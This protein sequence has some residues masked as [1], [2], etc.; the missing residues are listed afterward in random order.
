M[1]I[2]IT[3]ILAGV[4]YGSYMGGLRIIYDSQQDMERT[5]MASLVLDRIASDLACAF[6]RADKEYLVFVGTGGT[7]G[8]YPSDSV[9][10]I[11]SHYERS[12]RDTRESTLCEVSYFLDP[13]NRDELFILRRENPR[14]D[15]DP[16]S[17]GETRVIGEGV[18]GLKLEYNG[19][20]GWTSSWDSRENS[21]L[22]TAIR[23]SL[24]FRTEEAGG[25]EEGEEAVKY[26]TFV[27]ETAIPA[28]GNW[29]EKEED[30][31]GGEKQKK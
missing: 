30:E 9:T 21:S 27:T 14:L 2:L 20:E 25:G 6:L 13:G 29:E 17:S 8:E 11:S 5:H 1:A 24:V 23:I 22:P 10:F 15:E 12:G 4:I 7:G 19:E 28:G 18:A 3:S 31:T 16:F 26:T